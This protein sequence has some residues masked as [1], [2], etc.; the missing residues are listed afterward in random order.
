MSIF[1]SISEAFSQFEGGSGPS[2]LTTALQG[3]GLGGNGGIVNA[4]QENGLAGHVESWLSG[5]E[6]MPITADQLR[7]VLSNE[8]VQQ[9]ATHFGLPVDTALNLL[10]QPLPAAVDQAS[11]NGS[12]SDASA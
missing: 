6:N 10:A 11:L 7:A 2:I 12:L 5:G 9:I 4:L 3:T 1:G 8:Q